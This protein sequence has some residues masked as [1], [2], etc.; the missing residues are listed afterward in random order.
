MC[1][2]FYILNK[3]L[4][5]LYIPFQLCMCIISL[6]RIK[7]IFTEM[8]KIKKIFEFLFIFHPNVCMPVLRIRL[9]DLRIQYGSIFF[10]SESNFR[11]QVQISGQNLLFSCWSDSDLVNI[12]PDSQLSAPESFYIQTFIFSH[13]NFL[14]VKSQTSLRLH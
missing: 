12:N 6:K 8:K 11:I 7:G 2:T 3:N 14:N 13:E 9:A 4:F 5:I 1:K 10:S